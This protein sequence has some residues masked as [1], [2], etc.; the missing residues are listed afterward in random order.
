MQTRPVQISIESIIA[1]N[2]QLLLT[3]VLTSLRRLFAKIRVNECNGDFSSTIIYSRR[4][5]VDCS[6]SIQQSEGS[7]HVTTGPWRSLR[8]YIRRS[9]CRSRPC[10]ASKTKEAA[11]T[12]S[13]HALES[14]LSLDRRTCHGPAGVRV[15]SL[16]LVMEYSRCDYHEGLR[17]NPRHGRSWRSHH[18]LHCR[19]IRKLVGVNRRFHQLLENGL[20]GN[21][22]W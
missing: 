22:S 21:S 16:Q 10:S 1:Q 6:R 18:W 12:A 11:I 13:L 5:G 14:D 2:G 8:S 7:K 9:E 3:G 20:P 17:A 19:K 4:Y 15:C